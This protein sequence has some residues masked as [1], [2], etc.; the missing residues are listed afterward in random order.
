MLLYTPN[1][2]KAHV[3]GCGEEASPR[4]RG[5]S[6]PK[7]D[8][9]GAEPLWKWRVL[10]ECVKKLLGHDTCADRSEGFT[11]FTAFA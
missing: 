6:L 3:K 7:A 10:A 4:I 8:T 1:V 9:R 11:C 2:R 5:D